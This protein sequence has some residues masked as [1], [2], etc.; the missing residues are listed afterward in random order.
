MGATAIT[1][2]V[3]T[4]NAATNVPAAATVAK[5][6]GALVTFDKDDQK[7]LLLLKNNV[8]NVTHTAVIK[9]GN[10]IQ[11]V[12]DLEITLTG[13]NTTAGNEKAVVIESGRY[14]DVSGDNKGKVN[15]VSKDTTTGDQI[16]VRA[17][18]L[19]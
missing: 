10:G 16:E 11:G 18:V 6:D 1:K 3:I 14:M 2:T 19:P 9:A 12:S 5:D 7:I 15:I 8:S 17:I 4:R 13:T